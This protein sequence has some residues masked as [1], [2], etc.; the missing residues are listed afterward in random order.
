MKHLGIILGWTCIAL[1]VVNMIYMN[2]VARVCGAQNEPGVH[3]DWSAVL[4]QIK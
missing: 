4:E 3:H 2:H 1:F